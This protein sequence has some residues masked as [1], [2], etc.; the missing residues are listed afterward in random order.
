MEE[1]QLVE[2]KIKKIPRQKIFSVESIGRNFSTKAV[3]YVLN[4][5]KKKNEIG[6]ISQGLYYRPGKSRFF[7]DQPI[8][9]GTD[10][11]I[12]AVSKKTGELISVHG[13]VAL[14][15]IGLSTQVPMRSIYHTTGRS[16]Y[17]KV[18]GNN[19]VKLVHIN[20]KKIVMPN[21]V[22]C[23]VV[24][25]LW[26]EGKKYLT[27]LVVKK[28]YQRLGNKYFNENTKNLNKMPA[29]MRKVFINYQ[30]MKPDDPAL[31]EEYE[32]RGL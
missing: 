12:K 10:A 17:I 11:I 3:K 20:P 22:T 19:R 8:P 14:N 2:K 26:F 9:P 15:E 31:I 25:A 30:N 23:H 21:T 5:L 28:I 16:R 7:P 6:V 4:R 1:V 18:N 29:W 32:W 24:T 27:P 13:A